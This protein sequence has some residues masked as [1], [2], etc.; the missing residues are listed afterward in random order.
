MHGPLYTRAFEATGN[1]A[2]RRIVQVG[3]KDNSVVRADAASDTTIAERPIGICAELGAKTGETVDVHLLG[4]AD[5]EA[6]AAIARGSSVEA[7]A[8]GRAVATTTTND[9]VIGIALAAATASG[10][11]IPVLIAP[12][13]I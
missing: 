7:D 4:I 10:D 12:Q 6:G 3:T 8:T 2:K 11:I 13:R 9:F 5:C 1:I